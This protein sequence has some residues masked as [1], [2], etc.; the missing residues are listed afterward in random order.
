MKWKKEKKNVFI[1]DCNTNSCEILRKGTD[2]NPEITQ[3]VRLVLN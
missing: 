2:N 3:K 1:P